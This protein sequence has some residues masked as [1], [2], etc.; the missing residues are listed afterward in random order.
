MWYFLLDFA[1]VLTVWYF[2]LDFAAVLT[3]CYFLLDFAAV[4]TVW[5]F[6]IRFCSCSDSMVFFVTIKDIHYNFSV[7]LYFRLFHAVDWVPTL[8]AAAGGEQGSIS[9]TFVK[10]E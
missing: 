2:L 1:A 6:F 3:V 4:L 5:Y 8:V 10:S 7:Y 9:I